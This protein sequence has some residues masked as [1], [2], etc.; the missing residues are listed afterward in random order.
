VALDRHQQLML[1]VGQAHRA[2]LVLAPPLETAQGNPESQ[3]VLELLPR[4]PS[5][6]A[7]SIQF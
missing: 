7:T 5:Q 3:Q 2:R 4:R 1:C 6:D